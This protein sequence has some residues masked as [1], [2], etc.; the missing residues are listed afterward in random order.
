MSFDDDSVQA[1]LKRWLTVRVDMPDD[2]NADLFAKYFIPPSGRPELIFLDSRGNYLD[3]TSVVHRPPRM[4]M[5]LE[6]LRAGTDTFEAYR[7]RLEK[8]PG[9]LATW[10]RYHLMA[11]AVG[12]KKEA[13]R[14][15]S[16]LDEK[17]AGATGEALCLIRV[18]LALRE[19]TDQAVLEKLR[20]AIATPNAG[21][22]TQ[23]AHAAFIAFL[24]S[25]GLVSDARVATKAAEAVITDPLLADDVSEAWEHQRS[26]EK[27]QALEERFRAAEKRSDVPAMLDVAREALEARVALDHAIGW[28]EDL[29]ASDGRKPATLALYARLCAEQSDYPTA[30]EAIREALPGSPDARRTAEWQA[31]LTK[32]TA[33]YEARRIPRADPNAKKCG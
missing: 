20:R 16:K 30:I 29:L 9:D 12:D 6:R 14:T 13:D 33:A 26:D 32:W 2:R 25:R 11:T 4:R 22:A 21:R 7:R 10:V 8:N 18:S 27:R 3:R 19:Q 28:V 17:A 15:A 1:E 23:E 5:E 24:L 31:E